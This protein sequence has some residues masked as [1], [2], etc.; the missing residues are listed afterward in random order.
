MGLVLLGLSLLG[1]VYA[2]YPPRTNAVEIDVG[3]ELQV[4]SSP[5][6]EAKSPGPSIQ[7]GRPA[8][9]VQTSWI[10]P[11]QQLPTPFTCEIRGVPNSIPEGRTRLSLTY[12]CNGR[13]ISA[14][15]LR[16]N[17]TTTAGSIDLRNPSTLEI[18]ATGLGKQRL[19]LGVSFR[20]C[21]QTA[22]QKRWTIAVT[23]KRHRIVVR[24]VDDA[25]K[26]VPQAV[27]TLNRATRKR[28]DA[29]GAAQFPDLE[30]GEYSISVVASGFNEFTTTQRLTT[31][32]ALVRVPLVRTQVASP[33][34]RLSPSPT[35]TQT[36]SPTPSPTSSPTPSPTPRVSPSP[37]ATNAASP[38][39][40]AEVSPSVEVSPSPEYS[41]SVSPEASPTVTAS[42]SESTFAP[43]RNGSLTVSWPTSISS[44]WSNVCRVKY[45]PPPG[46]AQ[47]NVEA[48]FFLTSTS[49]LANTELRSGF[50]PLD[51][52]T[53][54]WNI[55]L[56][57][58]GEDGSVVRAQLMMTVKIGSES[59]PIEIQLQPLQS[60]IDEQ[61][62]TRNQTLAGSGLSGVM[63]F[64]FLGIGSIKRKKPG[65]V[66]PPRYTDVTIYEDHLFE[67][68]DL[69]GAVKVP[70]EVPLIANE[71]Y[72]LEVAIRLKRTG[73]QS[74]LPPERE[75][76]N[77]R[78]DEETLT[79]HVLATPV[80]GFKITE[81]LSTIKWSF[82][83]DSD[84]ALFRLEVDEPDD[85]AR[86]G[87]IEIRI[88]DHSLNLLDIVM[89][90]VGI[91]AEEGEKLDPAVPARKLD[92]PDKDEDREGL[93]LAGST[94][95]R[96]ASIHV[97][98]V[99]GGFTFEFV[100]LSAKGEVVNISI[101]RD[102]STDDLTFLLARVRD[103]WSRLVISNYARK[104][105]VSPSTYDAYLRDLRDLGIQAWSLLFDT[106][107]FAKEGASERLGQILARVEADELALKEA[108]PLFDSGEGDRIQISYASDYGD[109]IF[110]WSILHPPVPK[111]TPVDPL[112]FWGA[113]YQIEQVTKGPKKDR[114]DDRPINILFAL[115]S[116]FGDAPAQKKMFEDYQ[117]AS[118][119]ALVVSSPISD[120]K[121]LEDFLVSDPSAHLLYFYCHGY[122]ATRPG[123]LMA[124]GVKSLKAL[125]EGI[126]EKS[127]EG[128]S[129]TA[130]ALEKLMELTSKMAGESWIYL[131]DAEVKEAE[132]RLLRFFARRR[133]IVFLNMC[134]SAD[135]VPSMSS[136]LVHLFLDHNASAVIGTESPMTGVFAD[137]FAR[138]VFD[139]LFRGDNIGTALWK[140]RRHFLTQGRNP[141][142]LAYTLYGRADATLGTK[143]V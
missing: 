66:E 79:I 118:K 29:R 117:A 57:P 45:V 61:P 65:Y 91:V 46:T 134:Q 13:Q 89:L 101:F 104:L 126:R 27:V 43:G 114:I 18:D 63:G 55:P 82:N 142:G 123:L 53:R 24:V 40:S 93:T 7:S 4:L 115:D 20:G 113:R 11:P 132:L 6:L 62:L 58:A 14:D 84:S 52:T 78:K 31:G 129:P 67:P 109:F 72:T 98:Q 54:E 99:T 77:P 2:F 130:A 25:G 80:R 112:R 96:L 9:F 44:G 87:S 32:A 138:T 75:V 110:P 111:D 73:I 56:E 86:P 60:T 116:T 23:E 143:V 124:D 108:Q 127:T 37:T 92:W 71:L 10:R 33:S 41:P 100:L 88:L 141:L 19:T 59:S 36:P 135:L 1:F 28:T 106:R 81:R 49:G 128:D 83:A 51:Q 137:A 85:A 48:A 8:F 34:P 140:A 133:P 38:S 15:N 12:F 69:D 16:P 136:G 21:G 3:S 122:A 68:E 95:A 74:D 90:E 103:F 105:A 47:Q 131:G 5:E 125:I 50:Q 107:T 70:D 26:P 17:W 22:C 97:R 120:R 30:A 94:E 35:P 139:R 42:P 39:P 76:E 102:I 121:S 64:G 119:G